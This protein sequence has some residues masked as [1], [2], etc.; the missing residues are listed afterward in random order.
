M[1][2]WPLACFPFLGWLAFSN[3]E[4]ATN[5][6]KVKAM[7]KTTTKANNDQSQCYAGAALPAIEPGAAFVDVASGEHW[8]CI[9]QDRC[10]ENVRRFGA[11]TADLHAIRDWL[12][13]HG[14]RVVGMEST[15]V[16][17]I[18]LYQIL[19]DAGMEVGVVNARDLKCVKGRPKTDRLD[20]QWGQR[21]LSCGLLRYS[22]R[23]S[24]EICQMRAIWRM[25]EQRVKDASRSLQRMHKA[26]YE[27]NLLLGKVVTDIGG[28]T[29]MAIIE[30]ILAG[31]RDPVQLAKLRDRRVKCD[32]QTIAKA[33]Q[34]DYRPEQIFLLGKALEQY[35][36]L[37]EGLEDYDLQIQ[38]RL[39]KMVSKAEVDKQLRKE[40]FLLM[41]RARQKSRTT[42]RMDSIS[43]A[44]QLCGVDLTAI[45]G[46]GAALPLSLLLETG[47][48]MS[49]W[50][51]S[52]HFCSW[53]GLSPNPRTS[54]GKDLGTRTKKCSTPAARGFRQ[55]AVAVTH[56]YSY[57]GEFFRRMRARKGGAEAICA[58]A[59][60]IATIYYTMIKEGRQ[61]VEPDIDQYRQAMKE[62]RIKRLA[63]QA[64]HL[65]FTLTEKAA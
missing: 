32:E 36:F 34:G 28:K 60:K 6:K 13:E 12:L 57:L 41:Q 16:Y 4:K 9:P 5:P 21:L 55:A 29:G 14:V 43:C 15:G 65:G 17:W 1:K 51:T 25:R 45:P 56:S 62:Q 35:R 49:K 48:D 47:T 44:H 11:F 61:Y 40:N 20:C 7:R 54:A 37:I 50:P 27:M 52:K 23:P 59:H 22:F 38:Q 24:G 63:K 26:L 10:E 64:A 58:T 18:N 3:N 42:P 30:A 33:L 46:M 2:L 8:V 53:L 31:E 39:S 19:E